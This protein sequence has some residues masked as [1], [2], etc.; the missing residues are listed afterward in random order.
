M[1]QIE[2]KCASV[3]NHG[4]ELPCLPCMAL[5]GLV[6]PFVVSY[7]FMWPHMVLMLLLK[8]CVLD[9]V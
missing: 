7:G 8:L 4:I 3:A 5:C 1:F 9:T 6:C 2:Q